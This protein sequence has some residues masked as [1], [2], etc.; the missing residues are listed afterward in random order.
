MAFGRR[1]L[2]QF[3]QRHMNVLQPFVGLLDKEINE[4]FLEF[5]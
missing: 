2:L 5:I 4:L 1:P 3:V